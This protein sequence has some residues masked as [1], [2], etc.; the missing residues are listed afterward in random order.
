MLHKKGLKG[1]MVVLV[2][3]LLIPTAAWAGRKARGAAGN[4]DGVSLFSGVFCS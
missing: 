1:L 3:L 2:L 4:R